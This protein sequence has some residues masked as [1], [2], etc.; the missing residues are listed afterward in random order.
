MATKKYEVGGMTDT[1]TCGGPGKPKCRK[2]FKSKG[3]SQETKG[4]ILGTLGAIAGGIGAYGAYKKL[5]KE[6]KGGVTKYQKGG[7]TPAM[8]EAMYKAKG[9]K[10]PTTKETLEYVK[11][12][13]SGYIAPTKG[14]APA[15]WED[16]KTAERS[17]KRYQKGGT[18]K[19]APKRTTVPKKYVDSAIPTYKGP[20]APMPKTARAQN[21][22][23]PMAPPMPSPKTYPTGNKGIKATPRPQIG[24]KG[25]PGNEG[26]KPYG[27]RPSSPADYKA[28]VIERYG[29]EEAA[30]AAKAIQQKGGTTK[31]MK[32]GGMVN[33]NAKMQA[34]KT[35][36]SKGVKSGV[37]PKASASKRATGRVGGTSAAPKTAL[38]KAQ[39]GGSAYTP[40]N[41][42]GGTPRA[43]GAKLTPT[44]GGSKKSFK[45][46]IKKGRA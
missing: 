46:F 34:G 6:Q 36:G 26:Y 31:K 3:K 42:P 4:S 12:K 28:K 2:K 45:K 15:G 38:P 13:G 9:E 35:A 18:T 23:T 7:G 17:T 11:K 32:T 19:P 30:R 8:V 41:Q 5:K 14:K 40:G 24:G 39:M 10:V 16:G 43:G 25:N 44:A 29:S 21:G 27:P 37:N 22:G 20:D 33:P 1:Q